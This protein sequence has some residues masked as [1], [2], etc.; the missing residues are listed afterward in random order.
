MNMD[1]YNEQNIPLE[2]L[3]VNLN[4]SQL[5]NMN[6]CITA[7]LGFVLFMKQLDDY[8]FITHIIHYPY[9]LMI[10]VI[11]SRSKSRSF[12]ANMSKIITKIRLNSQRAI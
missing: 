1:N 4:D 5:T 8:N 10:L 2:D 12:V 6:T 9:L 3:F 7:W 11:F